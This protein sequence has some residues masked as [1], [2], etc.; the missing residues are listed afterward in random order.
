MCPAPSQIMDAEADLTGGKS[1][2]PGIEFVAR[3]LHLQAGGDES[4]L[5]QPERFVTQARIAED[6]YDDRHVHTEANMRGAEHFTF[7]RR[8]KGLD[9]EHRKLEELFV[10]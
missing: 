8:Q 4:S 2:L 6:G 10:R 3:K 9:F 7:L 5:A 1:F